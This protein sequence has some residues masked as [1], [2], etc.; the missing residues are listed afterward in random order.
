MDLRSKLEVTHNAR[1]LGG[2]PLAGGGVTASG[3]LFRSDALDRLTEAG[4]AALAELGVGTIVDLRT[5]GERHRAPDVVP[6]GV[7]FLAL[8][9]QGGAMD[10]LVARLLPADGAAH[11]F[12]DDEVQAIVAQIPSLAE[13][14]VA[15]LASSAPAFATLARTVLDAAG[16]PRPGVL[17]HCTA[18]KDRTGLSAAILLSV[19]GAERRAIID[20]YTRTGE[21]LA[22]PFAESLLGLITAL[23]LPVVPQLR[24]L[25]TE[26]P[27]AAI[28]AALEWI[29]VEHGDAAG[30]LR[31]GGLTEAET[32]RLREVLRG[33]AI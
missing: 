1:E 29:A 10:E 25:A 23:G 11:A 14:Y 12:T 24:S 15:I 4:A 7:A 27:A 9:V 16:T 32:A 6:D 3:I 19:A 5:D 31:S 17:F 2:I 21:N 8:P 22:G 30:Y 18:G 28:D 20:D 13:L 26:S 33:S